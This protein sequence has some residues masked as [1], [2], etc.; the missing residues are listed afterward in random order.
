MWGPGVPVDIDQ[1]IY[2]GKISKWHEMKNKKN[3][4]MSAYEW[5]RYLLLHEVHLSDTGTTMDPFL[6]NFSV[7]FIVLG[8]HWERP[9]GCHSTKVVVGWLLSSPTPTRIT[10]LPSGEVTMVVSVVI[11]L[12]CPCT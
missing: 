7:W 10:P 3:L 5:G 8:I 9:F 1:D 11:K 4:L 12:P 6:A 2:L